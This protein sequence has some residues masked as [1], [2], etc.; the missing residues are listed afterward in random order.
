[1][2]EE[3]T[4]HQQ[5]FFISENLTRMNESLASQGRK[6]KRNNL[7]N[8]SYTRDGIVTIKI[9]DRCKVIEVYHMN[10]FVRPLSW[11]DFDDEPFHDTS[12]DVSVQST[13]WV[14]FGCC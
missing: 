11:F 7:V 12:P 2:V 3:I 8:A 1:M 14:G 9:S 5:S 13:Y 4:L 6:L 10:D